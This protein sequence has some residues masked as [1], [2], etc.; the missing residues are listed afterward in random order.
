LKYKQNRVW[1]LKCLES[2]P[3]E[4]VCIAFLSGLYS[5]CMFL[6]PTWKP[7]LLYIVMW[8]RRWRTAST[9]KRVVWSLLI[10][11]DLLSDMVIVLWKINFKFIP[12][13]RE[14]FCGQSCYSCLVAKHDQSSRKG[15]CTVRTLCPFSTLL[16]E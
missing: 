11:N 4:C 12:C 5:V 2:L 9:H 15:G 7:S 16:K 10:T 14:H 3:F 1:T 13:M 6:Y 8:K